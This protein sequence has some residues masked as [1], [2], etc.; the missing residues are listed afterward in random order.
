MS[1]E[2]I[3]DMVRQWH[4]ERRRERLETQRDAFDCGNEL[5]SY[6]TGQPYPPE[7]REV[8]DG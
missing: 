2:R 1:S 5:F 6:I 8:Q 4:L 7:E 3:M